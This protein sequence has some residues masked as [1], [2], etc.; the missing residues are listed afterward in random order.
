MVKQFSDSK[1]KLRTVLTI[2]LVLV[3]VG[4]AGYVEC[5]NSSAFLLSKV[6][7]GLNGFDFMILI[8]ST[9]ALVCGIFVIYK[10][11]C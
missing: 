9:L 7:L 3:I 6:V 4:P 1:T 11:K 8:G 5:Q 10:N 2:I